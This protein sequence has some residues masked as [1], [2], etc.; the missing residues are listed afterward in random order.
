MINSYFLGQFYKSNFDL[1]LYRCMIQIENQYFF[2]RLDET[3]EKLVGEFIISS[4]I[5]QFYHILQD[6][7]PQRWFHVEEE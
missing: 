3:K 4:N 5:H 2:K 1:H 7:I 6:N